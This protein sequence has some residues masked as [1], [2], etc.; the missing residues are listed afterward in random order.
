MKIGAIV[1]KKYVQLKNFVKLV[2]PKTSRWSNS[3][4]LP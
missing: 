3:Y 2:W 4:K 1:L